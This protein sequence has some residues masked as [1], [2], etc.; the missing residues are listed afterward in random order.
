M[1]RP[2][3]L[4]AIPTACVLLIAPTSWAQ[5]PCL[6]ETI[7]SENRVAHANFGSAVAVRGERAIIG[8]Q[9]DPAQG[10]GAGAAYIYGYVDGHWAPQHV[11]L[12]PD[13]Q[14]TDSFGYA[15]AIDGNVALVGAIGDDDHGDMA[16]SAY[17]FR[18]DGSQWN[19]E[20]KL[21]PPGSSGDFMFGWSVALAGNVAVIGAPVLP[22]PPDETGYAFVY[23]FN[24]SAWTLDR[25]L[26]P[27]DGG[28]DQ[29][30]GLSVATDGT[31]VVVGARWNDV[32]A[33]DAGA[34]YVYVGAGSWTLERRLTASDGSNGD[35]FGHAVAIDGDAIFI[36]APQ[37][38]QGLGAAYYFRR[39]GSNWTQSQKLPA[40]GITNEN[41]GAFL[42]LSGGRLLV[43][44]PET[45]AGP[46]RAFAY[47]LDGTNWAALGELVAQPPVGPTASYGAAVGLSGDRALIGARGADAGCEETT[48]CDSGRVYAFHLD[49]QCPCPG[50]LNADGVV[51]LA[52]LSTLL[53]NFGTIDGASA[54]QGDIDDDA[55]VDIA[56]LALLLGAFGSSC[57]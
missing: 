5:S 13:G 49:G 2:P 54:D 48:S 16:G 41:F 34:A 23:S 20:Q 51:E 30:F 35:Q 45:Y 12:A 36:G 39:G 27:A 21:L 33:Q 22:Y 8:A 29:Q 4:A 42:A 24:G 26:Q 9:G 38:W 6:S 32:R 50:D 37:P 57:G 43:G 18:F 10:I 31:R 25:T 3:C 14:P 55:D 17:I 19:F 15:V 40:D 44:S 1:L 46:G 28:I 52:D 53:A 56:D 11:L 7:T 47:A